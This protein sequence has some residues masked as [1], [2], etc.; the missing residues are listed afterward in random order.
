MPPPRRISSRQ[1]VLAQWRG[2]D[3]APLETARADRRRSAGDV[4]SRVLT[5]LKMETRRGDIEI[6][7]VWN[8]AIDPTVASHAQPA[9]LHH[10]TLF[11]IVDSDVWKYEIIRYHREEILKRMQYSFGLEKIKKIHFRVG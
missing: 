3:L 6:V 11:V 9:N 7:K 8:S 1:R 10:G 2:V 4:I 5:N